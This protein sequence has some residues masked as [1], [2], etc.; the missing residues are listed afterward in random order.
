M[1]RYASIYRCGED[2]K[3]WCGGTPSSN[4]PNIS[5]VC[6]DEAP[7]HE[8]FDWTAAQVLGPPID[9]NAL[10]SSTLTSST[11]RAEQ[12]GTTSSPS[13]CADTND[14]CSDKVAQSVPIAVGIGVAIPLG[15][16]ALALGFLYVKEIRR[17]RAALQNGAQMYYNT[18]GIQENIG[19]VEFP[20]NDGAGAIEM[21]GHPVHAE[22]EN[23]L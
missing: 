9:P 4:Q 1:P 2:G 6:T 7:I 8:F 23:P 5:Q 15:I 22:L 10:S 11:P 14:I 13:A 18:G 19:N 20:K 21:A 3:F 17:Y 16:L 12:T